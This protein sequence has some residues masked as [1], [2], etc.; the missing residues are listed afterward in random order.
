[1]RFAT[2]RKELA[3]IGYL[4]ERELAELCYLEERAS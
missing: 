1:M 3:E 4:E 2:C